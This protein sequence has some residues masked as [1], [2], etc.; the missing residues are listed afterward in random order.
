[1][2][3]RL[4]ITLLVMAGVKTEAHSFR[5]QVGIGTVRLFVRTVEAISDIS[6]SDAGLKE[7]N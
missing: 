6:H 7:E 4:T 2:S 3:D 5:S 1:M